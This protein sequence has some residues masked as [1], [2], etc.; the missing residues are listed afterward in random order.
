MENRKGHRSLVIVPSEQ[1]RALLER[2][3]KSV[4]PFE[5]TSSFAHLPTPDDQKIDLMSYDFIFI[6]FGLKDWE[7]QQLQYVWH[8]HR[9]ETFPVLVWLSDP[10]HEGQQDI[11]ANLPDL[12]SLLEFSFDAS[13]LFSLSQSLKELR[14]TRREVAFRYNLGVL[15]REIAAQIDHL[16]ARK[17]SGHEANISKLCLE[18]MCAVLHELDQSQRARYFTTLQDVFCAREAPSVEYKMS[19]PY[20]GTSERVRKRSSTSAV[21]EIKKVMNS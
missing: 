18:E 13:D 20:S 12:D 10:E 2:T 21:T 7:I 6:S 5:H 15:T 9:M 1:R 14:E 4:Y 3:L 11:P 16:A 17:K 19:T 8:Q